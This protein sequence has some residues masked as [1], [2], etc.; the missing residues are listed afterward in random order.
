[1]TTFKEVPIQ[2]TVKLG[3]WSED[4]S[5]DGRYI[6]EGTDEPSWWWNRKSVPGAFYGYGVRLEPSVH[7]DDYGWFFG[8]SEE[9]AIANMKA[10][11]A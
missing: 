8:E 7:G 9:E 10:A 6:C 1:M 11:N 3:Y 5:N 4:G 2:Y